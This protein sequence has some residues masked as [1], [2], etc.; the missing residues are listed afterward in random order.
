MSKLNQS[1]YAA[2]WIAGTIPW[3]SGG[4]RQPK[5]VAGH[6]VGAV[7]WGR[8]SLPHVPAMKEEARRMHDDGMLDYIPEERGDDWRCDSDMSELEEIQREV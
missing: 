2:F 5:P 4:R 8:P 1:K 6:S 7:L 3:K